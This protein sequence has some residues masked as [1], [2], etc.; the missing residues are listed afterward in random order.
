MNRYESL[1]ISKPDMEEEARKAL[2]ER[3]ANLV[4]ENGVA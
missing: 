1:Y 4:T 2:I 3:F